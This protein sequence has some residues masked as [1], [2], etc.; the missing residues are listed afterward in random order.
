MFQELQHSWIEQQDVDRFG[1][2]RLKFRRS[3]FRAI[4]LNQINLIRQIK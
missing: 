4:A 1:N 3:K 2:Y